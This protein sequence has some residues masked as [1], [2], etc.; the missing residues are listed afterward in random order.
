[1]VGVCFSSV[2]FIRDIITEVAE[3]GGAEDGGYC[4]MG[5]RASVSSDE[6]APELMVVM[7]AQQ[8]EHTCTTE[9]C[10]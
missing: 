5:D 9:L 6:R 1:M 4:V 7:A 10:I 2:T 3:A 8:G